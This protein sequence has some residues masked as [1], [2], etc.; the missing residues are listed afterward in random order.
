ME[1]NVVERAPQN[2]RA[3][4][5]KLKGCFSA[6]TAHELRT[7]IAIVKLACELAGAETFDARRREA[8]ALAASAVRKLES[9]IEDILLFSSLAE[10][11]RLSRRPADLAELLRA[12]VVE[13]GEFASDR[14]IDLAVKGAR[15]VPLVGDPEV[16]GRAF[17]HLIHNA[18]RFSR[19]G[20]VVRAAVEADGTRAFVRIRDSAA[21]I[22]AGELALIFES[23]YQSAD[24]LTRDADGLGLGLSIA[25]KA[26][27]AHG[28]KLTVEPR[29]YGNVFVVELP[30]ATR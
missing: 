3:A 17:S 14:G 27:E 26:V 15:R 13:Q 21:P 20:G 19:S 24:P 7:P 23:F 1:T 29:G 2:E 12:A 10:G 8:L 25:R 30:L 16:L 18:V 28:G 5:E 11:R 22:P 9:R 4:L 6:L